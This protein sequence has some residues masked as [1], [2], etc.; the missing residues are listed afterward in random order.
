M[1]N[2]LFNIL[3]NSNKD[4]DNQKLMDYLSGKLS[5]REKHEV[6]KMMNDNHFIS[7]AVEGLENLPDKK[8]LQAYVDQLNQDLH[9]QIQKTKERRIQKRIREYPWIY[10][11]IILI[12]V[13]SIVGYVVIRMFLR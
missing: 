6:E 12:L 2:E 11:A 3:S 13:L 5:E 4:I 1:T 10:L 8:K 7:D 9:N